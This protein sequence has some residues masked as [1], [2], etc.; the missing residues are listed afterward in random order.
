MIRSNDQSRTEQLQVETILAFDRALADGALPAASA[1]G[2]CLDP[3][4]ECERLLEAVW[5]SSD[6][7]AFEFPREF[8][9]FSIVREVGQ[10]GFGVV[11]LA[12]DRAL[13]RN[14]A[15]KVP[16]PEVLVTPE[17][18]RRFLREAEAASRLDH[19]HIVPV[20]EVG[21]EGPICY[22][23]SAYCEGPT[24]AQWLRKQTAPVPVR[25]ASR[26]VAILAAAVAHAHERGILH[27]DLKPGNILLQQ[28]AGNR[29]STDDLGFVPRICD[30]GLAK[31]LDQATQDTRSGLPIGSPEYMSPEQAAGRLR[32]QGPATDVYA[33]GVILYELL[34]GRPPHRGETDLET[35]RLV[36]DQDPPSSRSLRPG[37]PRDLERI[38]LKCLEK[39]PA[40][41]YASASELSADLERFLEGRPVHARPV[42]VWKHAGKWAR[43]RPVH[44]ALA[45]VL[46]VSVPAVV[47][48]LEWGKA[49]EN[50][51]GDELR[52][53]RDRSRLI[54]REAV[55]KDVLAQRLRSPKQF[56]LAR[57]FA[58]RKDFDSALAFL[59]SLRPPEN[60]PDARGFAWYFLDRLYRPSV[61]TLA[62]LPNVIR[63]G[64]YRR[65]GRMIAL[66]D[67]ANNT[68]IVDLATGKLRKL[69]GESKHTLCWSLVFSPDGRTLASHSS[70]QTDKDW[71]R[72]EV[73][74]WNLE[75]GAALE[76]MPES[77]VHTRQILFSPD[78][79]TLVT[80]EPVFSNPDSPVRSWRLSDDRKRVSLGESVRGD[81]LKFR[82][83]RHRHGAESVRRPFQLS[84]AVSVTPDDG[85]TC[86]FWMEGGD[87]DLRVTHT[88]TSRAF[89]RIVGPEVVFVPRNNLAV[90]CTQAELDEIA[91]LACKLTGCARARP[92][93]HEL[94]TFWARFSS[95][96]RT[97]ALISGDRGLAV[98]SVRLI[99]V[100]TG[101]MVKEP[102]LALKCIGTT[103]DFAHGKNALL[104]TGADNQ[105]RLWNFSQWR[106][107]GALTGHTKEVW[108][109]A[110]SPDGRSLA[111]SSDDGTLKIWDVASGREQRTLTGHVSLVAAVAY[112]P[113]GT[114]LA[115]AGWDNRIRLWNAEGGGPLDTLSGHTG[116]VR[117]VAFSP[118]GT[119][120]AST[121]ED[122]M[123]RLWD[124]ATR[125]ELTAPL[126]GHDKP[127]FS[128][129]FSLRGKTL[130]TGGTDKTIRLWDW[131]VGR[132]REA[133]HADDEVYTLA[134]S[135]DGETLAAGHFRG[136][137][138]L[139]DVAQGKAGA[140]LRGSDGDV[141]GLAFS[142]DG[143]TLASAG[144]DHMVRL[145][146]PVTGD[147]VLTLT[148]HEAPVHAIAF[149]PD[150]TIL[151]T[152]SHDGAIKLWRASP[153]LAN[154]DTKNLDRSF[155]SAY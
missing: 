138:R 30:F 2:P 90:R 6:S 64:A 43:R 53:E 112:S 8:G 9:R 1:A 40:W 149:S 139:W 130:Y 77:F 41:R 133:W 45:I 67:E 35:L 10:G 21:E 128:V 134:F 111:S 50:R 69:Q 22:I 96:A 122:R 123:I 65:D 104:M 142:P 4:H 143:R 74:L 83:S 117:T 75:S 154:Q 127:V 42:P 92:I 105:A 76:G 147:E 155:L 151:A 129:A 32:E 66:A 108:C 61:K 87:I 57:S 137:I 15:L 82:L 120:L 26:L 80:V 12:E 11:F 97:A 79:G 102:P 113:D 34:T 126:R 46:A 99:D 73:R 86:A 98:G 63:L 27:R 119:A 7:T 19:P 5:P 54:A 121:G 31:L 20:F 114:R 85:S 44:A 135:P 107:P 37:L 109:L 38:V 125:H 146:D 33:L 68:F 13:G 145:W 71:T 24:L 88:G 136:A 18:R 56:E 70:G 62:T 23:A 28:R 101:E 49:R 152:G 14:V 48:G 132:F 118:D 17:V 55:E 39:R 3:G 116:H 16:R 94:P 58:D 103:F 100:A 110:F 140:L 81:E 52:T 47:G 25:L 91:R 95:D 84:D 51:L 60:T 141:L 150:G 153:E 72:T 106:D 59:D 124:V 115:S 144:R 89:C 93:G 78:G 36:S 148:G 131:E 29:S